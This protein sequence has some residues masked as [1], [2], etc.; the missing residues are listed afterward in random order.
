MTHNAPRPGAG[1]AGSRGRRIAKGR[2][3][4]PNTSPSSTVQAVALGRAGIN[5]AEPI[6]DGI[7]V[8]SGIVASR[9][10]A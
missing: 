10:G 3:G 5:R 8:A 7:W 9:D 6:G 1:D 4:F 2:Y